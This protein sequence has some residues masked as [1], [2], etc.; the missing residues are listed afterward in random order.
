MISGMLKQNN[1]HLDADQ[2]MPQINH[3]ARELGFADVGVSNIDLRQAEQQLLEWLKKGFHGSM[4]YMQRHGQKR[5]RAALLVPGTVSILS[6]RMDYLPETQNA[7]NAVLNDPNLAYV[8]RYALGR[9]YH[10][11]MRQRLNKLAQRIQQYI[12]EFSYRVF[13]DSAPVLEKPIAAKAGLGWVGKHSNLMNREAGSWFFLGEIYLDFALPTSSP[14]QNHCGD[15]TSCMT[16]CPTQAIVA[17]YVVDARKC[18]S[19]L[20]IENHGDIPLALRP[21]LGNRIYGCDDCQLFCPWNKEA[22]L[23]QETDFAVRRGL[24]HTPLAELFL[25]SEADFLRRLEGSAI[26]RIG[27]QNWLRNIAV[28]LGNAHKTSTNQN[29]LLLRK[30]HPEPRVKAH[31]HWAL[32]Q[33][34]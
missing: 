34:Q 25:W 19:Y 4:S 2:L 10:K 22:P 28:A 31:I 32:E 14:R 12:G 13:T 8:S 17:P 7:A 6:A 1:T 5:T 20:T 30:N 21:K 33:Y 26:R 3:W 15:C 27:Y 18:I 29:A 9:D 24:N 23:S 11:L 16:V